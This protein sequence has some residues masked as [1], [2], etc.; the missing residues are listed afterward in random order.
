MG[1][2]QLKTK[3]IILIGDVMLDHYLIGQVKRISPEAPVPIL[4]V[5]EEDFRLGGA[6][7]VANNIR[8]L[9]EEVVL[10]GVIGN[11]MYGK[12]L[13]ELCHEQS[14]LTNLTVEESRPT[15][16][17]TRLIG[18]HQQMVRY[19]I[20]KKDAVHPPFKKTVKE[21]LL[22]DGMDWVILSDYNKGVFANR[23]CREVIEICQE[24]KKKVII[25]PKTSKWQLY[26]GAYLITPNFKEFCEAVGH[27]VEDTIEAI[28]P[29]ALDLLSKYHIENLLVTRS[30]KGM[31]L[32]NQEGYIHF[33]S[34]AKEVY[35]VTGAGDTVLSTIAAFLNKGNDLKEAVKKAN[36]AAGIVVSKFGT[37]RITLEELQ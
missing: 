37:Q 16:L 15:T 17:K 26:Q 12:K 24:N 23:F 18:N 10:L 5:L 30:E 21:L 4:E 7:N 14:I 22:E 34:E 19:D 1:E 2:I 27:F 25:D 13:L 35:D 33:P 29:L 31:T 11:D 6:A 9:Q 28:Q 32:F 20:E 3:R 36:I 8:G